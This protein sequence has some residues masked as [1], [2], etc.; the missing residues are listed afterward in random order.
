MEKIKVMAEKFKSF[1]GKIFDNEIECSIHEIK[2]R[3]EKG[4]TVIVN[5]LIDKNI[6]TKFDC[7]ADSRVDIA[8]GIHH[9]AIDC[10]YTRLNSINSRF[11]ENS[12]FKD[13]EIVYIGYTSYNGVTVYVHFD[14]R[15]WN[16][17]IQRLGWWKN[18]KIIKLKYY[19]F[20]D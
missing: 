20:D 2:K 3:I 10:G 19:D 13:K 11:S 6:I 5:E 7:C 15:D 16:E 4:E 9:G 14:K 1:D 8:H 12:S 17:E 18:P